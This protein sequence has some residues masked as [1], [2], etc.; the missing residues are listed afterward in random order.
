AY[1]L[2]VTVVDL[3]ATLTCSPALAWCA[4]RITLPFA[5]KLITGITGAGLAIS[6]SVGVA[7]PTLASAAPRSP[8]PPTTAVRSS[9]PSR[10]APNH[11]MRRP[12]P[13]Y[14]SGLDQPDPTPTSTIASDPPDSLAGSGSVP[15]ADSPPTMRRLETEP[16]APPAVA[17][18]AAVPSPPTP[19]GAVWTIVPGDHLWRVASRTLA[20]RWGRS[21][22]DDETARYLHDLIGLNQA[23][24]V[25]AD[26]PDLVLPGQVFALPPVPAA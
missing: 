23:V 25:V 15:A 16:P 26:D 19:G 7:A 5:R 14:A 8:A 2:V 6:L 24:L 10:P 1:L 21:A 18:P 12:D 3:A 13:A 11:T 4:R 20:A 17:P 22:T 9:P